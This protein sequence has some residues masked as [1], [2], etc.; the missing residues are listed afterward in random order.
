M[1][2]IGSI[3]TKACIACFCRNFAMA[4]R[5]GAPLVPAPEL[6][7]RGV[8]NAFFEQRI[9]PM[10]RGVERGDNFTRAV[11]GTGIFSSMELQI[12]ATLHPKNRASVR[13]KSTDSTD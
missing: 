7:G 4:M 5:S 13:H 1:P 2:V 11:T 12:Q 9:L 3:I 8:G 10:R 6:A